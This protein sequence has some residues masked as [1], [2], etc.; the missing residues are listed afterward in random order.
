VSAAPRAATEAPTEA[1]N[2]AVTP[3]VAALAE[4]ASQAKL[5]YVSDDLPGLSRRRS[6][7]GFSYYGV[8]GARITDR[9]ERERLK[10][11]AIPPAWREVWICPYK[12]GHIQ[13]TGRDERGRKQYRYHPDWHRVRDEAKFEHMLT[14][15]R[16]LPQIRRRVEKDLRLRGLPK[17]KVLAAV[18]R[19]LE[20]TLIRIGNDTYAEENGSYG[21]T[22]MRKKHVEVSG[23]EV[24]FDFVGKSGKAWDIHLRDP[25]VARIVKRCEEI[26]GYRLFRYYDEDGELRSV[27]S[28]DVN[29][30]LKRITGEEI[31]AKDF[32]TWAGTVLATFTLTGLGRFET[33]TQATKNVSAVIKEV[34]KKL[35]N[36][37]AVCRKSYVHPDVISCYLE[38][39]LE[40]LVGVGEAV[41]TSARPEGLRVEE[42]AVLSFLEAR[43]QVQAA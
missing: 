25:Q 40:N 39:T 42:V 29:D 22:T 33:E 15:G 7:K 5:R 2:E 34:A 24:A 16:L 36:T 38:G 27:E 4:A 26:P 19:L 18:V 23:T 32:R 20:T 13:A 30:Y 14:F 12:N 9:R 31:T 11:L 41:D 17:D 3:P 1:A 35:G 28:A 37:P 43:H 21:L 10:A 8:D 6:G